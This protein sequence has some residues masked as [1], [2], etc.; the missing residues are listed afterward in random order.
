MGTEADA[1]RFSTL[2]QVEGRLTLIYIL[3]K[4]YAPAASGRLEYW[5]AEA[6]LEGD[7]GRILASQARAFAESYLRSSGNTSR[8]TLD[9]R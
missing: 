2:S 8:P 9:P 5:F 4:N 3:E 1:V 6:R 7:A